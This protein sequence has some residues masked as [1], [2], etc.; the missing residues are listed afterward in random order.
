M[1]PDSFDPIKYGVLWERVQSYERRFDEMSNKIDKL[2]TSIDKLVE[3]A[4]QSKGG[5]WMGMTIVSAL[6]SV[7][8]YFLHWFNKG[9]SV[10]NA[11]V[12]FNLFDADNGVGGRKQ[13]NPF[14]NPA[15]ENREAQA[16]T[17]LFNTRLVC[18]CMDNTRS[19]GA[20]CSHVGLAG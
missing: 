15:R 10:L 2:E 11:L 6:G 8:G 18:D 3:M 13:V 7:A 20:P 16:G 14:G 4:N 17:G 12:S 9:Q 19:Y 5:F 1:T